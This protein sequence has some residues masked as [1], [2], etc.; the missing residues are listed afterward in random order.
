[1]ATEVGRYNSDF[2]VKRKDQLIEVEIKV[3]KSDLN[4]DFKKDKHRIYESGR[5]FWTPNQFYFAVPE[6]I[7][8]YAAAKI[9]GTKY[10]LLIIAPQTHAKTNQR[11]VD[12][13]DI[14]RTMSW[15]KEIRGVSNIRR[16][17][18]PDPMLR[19]RIHILY[20]QEWKFQ[21]KDCVRVVKRAKA[22]HTRSI[23]ERVIPTI[24]KRMSS[25]LANVHNN[26]H[27]LSEK[28]KT[29]TKS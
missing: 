22:I 29:E 16:G 25:E 7:A 23:D 1:M 8:E 13:Y 17:D 5:S 26:N 11:W 21:P 18:K 6:S 20:D 28:L 24:V 3:S 12:D 19:D 9:A 15:I 4:N 14:E 10:G 27:A 2:L